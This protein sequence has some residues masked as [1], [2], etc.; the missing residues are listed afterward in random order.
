MRFEAR[1]RWIVMVTRLGAAVRAFGGAE[2]FGTDIGSAG[3]HELACRHDT[4]SSTQ[5]HGSG[6]ARGPSPRAE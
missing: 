4:E 6:R 1:S 3:G 5:P 2:H